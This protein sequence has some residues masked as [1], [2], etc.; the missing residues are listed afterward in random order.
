[1]NFTCPKP[2]DLPTKRADTEWIVEDYDSMLARSGATAQGLRRATKG[3]KAVEV[4]YQRAFDI[5][6][7]WVQWAGGRH[8][9]VFKGHYLQWLKMYYDNP[10]NTHLV[11]IET[12]GEIEGIFGWESL[13]G[14]HQV[15][16]AK[17]TPRLR[18]KVMWAVGLKQ[19]GVG[20]ILCG[21]TADDLKKQLGM[22]PID[23]WTFDISQ[24]PSDLPRKEEGLL[25]SYRRRL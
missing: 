16:L 7:E 3:G 9:M 20:R 10:A 21:S 17:H 12:D 24:I 8:Y 13:N 11:G 1:M 6:Q 18:G 23:S 22:T 2:T 14:V 15:T 4:P 25:H 19:I 5:F